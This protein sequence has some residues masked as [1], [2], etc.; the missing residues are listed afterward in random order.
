MNATATERAGYEW[1]VCANIHC[2]DAADHWFRV[3]T[4]VRPLCMDHA[5]SMMIASLDNGM[6]FAIEDIAR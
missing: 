1:P 6:P 3:L 2:E 5:H 4:V